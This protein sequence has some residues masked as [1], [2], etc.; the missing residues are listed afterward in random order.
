VIPQNIIDEINDKVSILEVIGKFTEIKKSGRNYLALCPFH[1]EKTPSFS[2][3]EEKGLYH[4]F[5]CG[6]SGNAIKFLMDYQKL[7]F[8]EALQEL[9]KVAGIDLERFR[10]DKDFHPSKEK[11]TFILINREAMLYYHQLLLQETKSESA[12]EY[13]KK[14]KITLETVKTFRLGFGGTDWSGIFEHLKKK[15]FQEEDILKAG[16]VSKGT[17]GFIDRF[18]ERI[19]FPIFDKEG[20][21][22]GFGGRILNED[23]KVAKYLN[24]A[25]NLL[26]HKGSLLYAFHLAKDEI[27]RKKEAILVEGYMDVIALHQNGIQNV[28]A[29]LGT[30]LTENQLRLIKRYCDQVLFAF[31]G[32]SAGITAANRAIDI[33]VRSDLSQNVVILNKKDPYDYVMEHGAESFL[34]YLK[35]KRLSPMDFKIRYFSRQLDIHTEKVKFLLLLFP[36]INQTQ[37]AVTRESYLKKVSDY[38]QE[39]FRL[40]LSE[41]QS[42]LK[43]DKNLGK[44]IEESKRNDKKINP[45]EKEFVALWALFPEERLPLQTL[46]NPEMLENEGVREIFQFIW[47]NPMKEAKEIMAAIQ[48]EEMVRTISEYAQREDIKPFLLKELAYRL[49]LNYIKRIMAKNHDPLRQSELKN[50][51]FLLEKELRKIEQSVPFSEI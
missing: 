48:N 38:I 42:F 16:L 21:V 50:E 12:R 6:A 37:S 27:S 33:A 51:S 5:G 9:S 43:K 15:G 14:R 35:E 26:F 30:A 40:I 13:L 25:E 44:R 47:E 31:D 19:I 18:R 23:K 45:V 22:T 46:I 39:D 29:P 2:I 8:M 4:C 36:Y 32:D 1:Q 34:S 49:K 11:E 20:E 10:E 41:Y 17:N 28:V 24:S 3:S 7:T